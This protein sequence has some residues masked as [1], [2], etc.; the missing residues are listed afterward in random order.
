MTWTSG[1]LPTVVAAN[2]LQNQELEKLHTLGAW[3]QRFQALQ[4]PG[5]G[6]MCALQEL[7]MAWKSAGRAS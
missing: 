5:P 6:E 3:Y 2:A 1:W 7:G 4:M